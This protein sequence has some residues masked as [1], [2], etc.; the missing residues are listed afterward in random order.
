MINNT[1]SFAIRLLALC[2][3]VAS[4]T[5][6]ATSPTKPPPGPDYSVVTYY[7]NDHAGSP[8]AATD[9]SGYVLWR[10]EYSPY[11]ERVMRD[12]LAGAN[13]LWF[14]GHS[15]DEDSGLTYAGARHYDPMIG[16]FMSVDPI[17]PD[18][19][20]PFTFNRYA[21]GNNNPYRY[22][23]PNGEAVEAIA[24]GGGLLLLGYA[25]CESCREP[26]KQLASQAMDGLGETK[27]WYLGAQLQ[28]LLTVYSMIPGGGSES[29][30]SAG[31]NSASLPPDGPDDED[32]PKP[33]R[34]TNKK[35][36][37]NS[38]SPEPKN[39]EQ[40]YK[41][42]VVDKKGVRWT[43]DADG[44]IHRFSKPSNGQTHWN[45][46]TGGTNPIRPGDIPREIR[47]LFKVKG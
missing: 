1:L 46:S 9:S 19:A 2:L 20:D 10:E 12:P 30:S 15:H 8:L 4:G 47:K 37:P 21:Y 24:V 40:L 27:N 36:H 22:L 13:H 34:V 11:G 38:E 42:S 44:I 33:T 5:A 14:T 41:D 29:N 32:D 23:D 6:S 17:A 39:V 26:L 16:R 7:H 18:A 45:G 28:T 3:L 35:H 43:K 31:A 25:A